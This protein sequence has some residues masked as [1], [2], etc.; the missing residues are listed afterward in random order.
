MLKKN[1]FFIA[2]LLLV[3]GGLVEAGEPRQPLKQMGKPDIV[4]VGTPYDIVSRMLKLA[5][6]KK[7][8]LVYDLGCGDGRMVVLAAQ[9]YGCRGKGFDIDPGQVTEAW[10]N[11]QRNRVGHLVEIAQ[12]DIFNLDFSDADV[13][14]LYLASTLVKR[15]VPKFEKLK[16]GSR[17]VVHNDSIEGIEADAIIR[18]NSNEDNVLHTLFVYSVPFKPAKPEA[19]SGGLRQDELAWYGV[20]ASGTGLCVRRQ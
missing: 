10:K 5:N 13:L 6:V 17:L 14:V 15:L 8:D 3:W 11:V 18:V 1:L 2:G 4:Y 7:E 19:D 20:L 12:A 9:K 16:P